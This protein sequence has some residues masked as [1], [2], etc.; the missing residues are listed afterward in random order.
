MLGFVFLLPCL[1]HISKLNHML[2]KNKRNKMLSEEV[3]K[4][5]NAV[6][7]RHQELFPEEYDCMYDSTSEAKARRR[8]I[9]PMRESYQK[10]VNLRRLK[11]GVEPYMGNVGVENIDTSSLMTSLEYCKKVEHEKKT[12]K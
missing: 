12:N 4:R 7:E 6:Y 1:L 9:N 8:G 10:E 3:G 5:D 11:L 2:S